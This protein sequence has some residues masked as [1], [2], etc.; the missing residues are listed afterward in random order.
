MALDPYGSGTGM[1]RMTDSLLSPPISD[2]VLLRPIIQGGMGVGV[3]GWRLARAVSKLGQ[4]GVV[5]GAVLDLLLARRLQLGA[6]GGHL[7]RAFEAFP[8][9]E[10]AARIPELWFIPGGKAPDAT[11]KTPPMIS[12]EPARAT[13]EPVI[14]SGFAPSIPPGKGIPAWLV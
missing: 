11:F 6:P 1:L 4:P 10:I 9:P 3:S 2:A 5:S 8:F 13:R 14:A 7:R 12:R